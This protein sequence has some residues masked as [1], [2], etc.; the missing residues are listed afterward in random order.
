VRYSDKPTCG[1]T[2]EGPIVKDMGRSRPLWR[3]RCRRKVAEAGLRC[4]Q[5][6]GRR[7]PTG[8]PTVATE[9]DG[10]EGQ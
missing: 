1:A 7:K 8:S 3:D 4:W 10:G 5:H 6:G 9:G 2:I